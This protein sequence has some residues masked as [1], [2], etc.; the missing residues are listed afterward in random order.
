MGHT[1][2]PWEWDGVDEEYGSLEAEALKGANGDLV[3]RLED[4]YPG[5]PECGEHLI[6]DMNS[7][8]ARL[9]L[10]A[11]DLLEALQECRRVILME[12]ALNQ[13]YGWLDFVEEHIRPALNKAEG[14]E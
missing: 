2:G 14:K 13:E 4:D 1:K 6:M 7:D 3:I 10:S 5:Y 9:I 12:H 11:P 8:D